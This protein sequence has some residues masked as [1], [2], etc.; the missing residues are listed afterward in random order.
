MIAP[1]LSLSGVSKVYGM[2][3]PW[4]RRAV[5]ALQPLSLDLVRGEMTAVLGESGSGKT[6]LARLCLGL[7]KPSSGSLSF[8]GEAFP[9]RPGRLR[10]R[11]AAVLQNPAAALNPVLTVQQSIAEPMRLAGLLSHAAIRTRVSELLELVRLPA[12]FASRRPAELSGGQRQRVT[13]ARALSTT[14]D[15]IVFDEAVSALDASVQ[16]Q[17]LN[18]ID[19]LKRQIGF[20]GLFITHDVAVARYVGDRALVMRQGRVEAEMAARDLYRPADN[21]YA[22]SLQEASGLFQ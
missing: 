8:N 22:R 14:P 12:A 11:L 19:D 21:A 9:D 18:L 5:H 4:A 16:A 17:V 20:A 15:L 1:V 7:V 3:P 6:T 2:G 13:I 10:G